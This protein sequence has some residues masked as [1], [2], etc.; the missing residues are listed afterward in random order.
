MHGK[1]KSQLT[2]ID[3]SGRFYI[4]CAAP[5]ENVFS[6]IFGHRS[7]GP[8]VI[9]LFSCSAQQLLLAFSFLLAEIISCSAELSMKKSFI[10]SGP[11][12][13]AYAGSLIMVFRVR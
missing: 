2:F 5:C 11:D 13:Y 3:K 10:T 6:G 8:E 9:K 4:I 12:Q 1:W 7:R